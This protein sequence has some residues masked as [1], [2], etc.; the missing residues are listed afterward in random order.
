MNLRDGS[1]DVRRVV[2]DAERICDVERAPFEREVLGIGQHKA[3]GLGCELK[4]RACDRKVTWHEVDTRHV[5][6]CFGE[7]EQIG[8]HPAAHLEHTRTG[9]AIK[10]DD[11]RKPGCV[12]HIAA[13]IHRL[14]ERG[15]TLAK[16]AAYL[17]PTRSRGPVRDRLGLRPIHQSAG[18]RFRAATNMM[19]LRSTHPPSL[20]TTGVGS[21]CKSLSAIC[22]G[23]PPRSRTVARTLNSV[24]K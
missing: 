18:A 11:F 23:V 20:C 6:A 19:S 10:A 4:S 7:L 3:R 22:P 15:R 8:T 12:L 16:V 1:S 14:E 13:S 2:E 5:R 21:T 24:W 9:E 17:C